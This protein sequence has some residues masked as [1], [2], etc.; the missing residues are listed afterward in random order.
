MRFLYLIILIFLFNSSFSQNEKKQSSLLWEIT[1]NGISSPSYLYGTMHVSNKLAFHLGDS[2][3]IALANV[4]KVALETNPGE[5]MGNMFNSD[6]F[7]S[8]MNNSQFHYSDKNFYQDLIDFSGPNKKVLASALRNT[9]SLQNGFL[10]RNSEYNEDFEEDTYLDL[11]I[12]QYAKKSNL[13]VVSLENYDETNILQIKASLP[14]NLTKEERE[15]R[16]RKSYGSQ[17][18]SEMSVAEAMEDAYRKGDLNIIDSIIKLTAPSDNYIKYF[19]NQRNRIMANGIDSIIPNNPLFIGIGAAHLPGDSGVINMLKLK[20]YKLR[21]VSR[22]S[23]DFARIKKQSI[24]ETFYPIKSSPFTT[25]DGYITVNTPAKLYETNGQNDELEYFYPEM[26]NGGYYQISRFATYKPLNNKSEKDWKKKLDS[27]FFENIEGKIIYQKDI[28]VGDFYGTDILNKTRKGDYQRR[29]ILYTPLE[30]IFFKMGGTGEWVKI[31]G[32]DFFESIKINEEYSKNNYTYTSHLNDF[33]ITF[34]NKPI[35]SVHA[36]ELSFGK[37][38]TIQHL[39]PIDSSYYV[40]FN[41]FIN[42]IS[43]IEED[44]F[45]LNHIIK[46]FYNQINDSL[47]FKINQTSYNNRIATIGEA[48]WNEKYLITK[49]ILIN[50]NYFLLVAYGNDSIKLTNYLNS[51]TYQGVKDTKETKLWTD[52]IRRYSV[53]TNVVP[54]KTDELLDKVNYLHKIQDDKPWSVLRLSKNFYDDQT[55][56]YIFVDYLKHSNYYH[57]P[58][59]E[60]LW[61]EEFDNIEETS[62]KLLRATHHNDDEF[63]NATYLYGD[64]GS[65]KVI[66]IKKIVNKGEVFTLTTNYDSIS[67]PSNFITTFYDSFTPNTDSLV[68]KYILENNAQLFFNDLR[69][70]D[71]LRIEKAIELH[72][73]IFYKK[74]HFDSLVWFINNF[75]WPEDKKT[76]IQSDLILEISS[77]KKID[78]IPFLI[79]K[80]NET[81]QPEIQL[82]I[83]KSLSKIGTKKAYKELSKLLIN[84]PPIAK[85]ENTIKNLFHYLD[86]SLTLSKSLFPDA[87]DLLLYNEYRSSVYNMGSMLLDSN[88]INYKKYKKKK[89]LILREAK[90]ET[91]SYKYEYSKSSDLDISDYKY[92]FSKKV[93]FEKNII[94]NF[95]LYNYINLLAPYHSKDKEVQKYFNNTYKNGP[96]KAKMVIAVVSAKFDISVPDSIILRLSSDLKHAFVYYTA[97][98]Q[99]DKLNYFDENNFSQEFLIKS[100]I[101]SESTFLNPKEDTLK[102]IKKVWFKDNKKEGYIYFYSQEFTKSGKFNLY[103][104]GLQPIDTNSLNINIDNVFTNDKIPYY[105]VDEREEEIKEILKYLKLRTRKRAYRADNYANEWSY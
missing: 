12:Y 49:C 8:K 25:K 51:F 40:I 68:G 85:Y 43:Y 88:L 7:L 86:D 41:N 95:D 104:I 29:L 83:L 11:F 15:K 76:E 32:D 90:A 35:H 67:G 79:S 71:S 20:G 13:P 22:K 18:N 1:G 30:I 65:S 31:N 6:Y 24:E 73:R 55:R 19:L 82:A 47:K 48:L 87:W 94:S 91:Q 77:I 26:S 33:K 27:L 53:K 34:P 37:K 42:D 93:E 46:S 23:T 50:N 4:E 52:S 64:T 36:P 89:A 99:L 38:I 97:L 102:L 16:K 100:A 62:L 58:T 66:L 72:N 92:S 59:Y 101:Y 10:Y 9:H 69:S 14:D 21:P 84:Q 105:T 54:T 57:Q 60:K 61:E 44:T 45:E 3:F 103:H 75:D 81:D 78:P 5:W 28:K 56:N 96:I 70:G 74:Q 17:W 2:F 98:K 80:Y 39:N 63:P